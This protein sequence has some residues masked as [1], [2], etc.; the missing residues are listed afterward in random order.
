M[1]LK[2]GTGH[3]ELMSLLCW[4]AWLWGD[5]SWAHSSSWIYFSA[6]RRLPISPADPTPSSNFKSWGQNE[7]DVDSSPPLQT[8]V[9][10]FPIS[11]SSLSSLPALLTSGSSPRC[12]SSN[13]IGTLSSSYNCMRSNSHATSLVI[14]FP[15]FFSNQILIKTLL[16]G[17]MEMCSDYSLLISLTHSALLCGPGLIFADSLPC[18]LVSVGLG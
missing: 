17:L 11:R 8:P 3:K 18:P 14:Y 7:T 10:A 13:Y 2:V 9:L 16:V 15:W 6:M 1:H 5:S 12:R 4:K